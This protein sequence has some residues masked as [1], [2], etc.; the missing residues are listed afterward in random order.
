MPDSQHLLRP[1]RESLAL[2]PVGSHVL[3]AKNGRFCPFLQ[4]PLPFHGL[5]IN[6]SFP[7]WHLHSAGTLLLGSTSPGAAST[8]PKSPGETS[9]ARLGKQIYP[10]L[11]LPFGVCL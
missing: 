6:A 2:L 3:L 8:C 4:Q 10:A 11:T 7:C 9:V 5:C 1:E